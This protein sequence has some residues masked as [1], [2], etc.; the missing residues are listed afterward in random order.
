MKILGT[1]IVVYRG[2]QFTLTYS[3]MNKD[4]VPFVLSQDLVNP[5]IVITVSSN[6]YCLKGGYFH[7]YWLNLV[8]YPKFKRTTP[9]LLTGGLD[10][11]L[12]EGYN[13]NDTVFYIVDSSNNME[14]YYWD[15][16]K[17]QFVKYEFVFSKLF[18][19]LDT[20]EWI[21]SNYQYQIHLADG[22]T[23][24]SYLTTIF[25]TLYP[26]KNPPD[27][28]PEIMQ[29]ICKKRP[30]LIKGV[31]PDSPLVNFTVSTIFLGPSKLTI[32]ANS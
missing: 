20:R 26:D 18:L 4:G 24:L 25:Q 22:N 8:D 13:W 27:T 28:V 30:D 23:T 14:Y 17:L 9:E 29:D 12:P 21:E 6:A 31:A 5:Y 11:G 32:K 1:N 10:G 16:V 15:L 19:S 2:E 3:A 7:R